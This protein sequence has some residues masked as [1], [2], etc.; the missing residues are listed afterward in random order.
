[1]TKD[2]IMDHLDT[3]IEQYKDK[4][5]IAFMEEKANAYYEGEIHEYHDS[6]VHDTFD[7]GARLGEWLVSQEILNDLEGLKEMLNVK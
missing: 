7:G 1:M 6:H 5:D 2:L 4:V 3:L